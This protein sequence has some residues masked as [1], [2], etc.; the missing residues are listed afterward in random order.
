MIIRNNN[1]MVISADVNNRYWDQG[2]Y[3]AWSAI[4]TFCYF[5]NQ[6]INY[7]SEKLSVNGY[8]HPASRSE[9]SDSHH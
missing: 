3:P 5:P 2:F 9:D 4:S 7:S 8:A 6:Q 1:Y